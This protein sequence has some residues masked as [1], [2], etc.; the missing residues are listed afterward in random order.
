MGD[1]SIDQSAKQAGEIQTT[2][3]SALRRL[4]T[5]VSRTEKLVFGEQ[6]KADGATPESPPVSKVDNYIRDIKYLTETTR[7]INDQLELL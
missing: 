3:S 1:D 4:R 6:P 5:Q 7:R 2:I